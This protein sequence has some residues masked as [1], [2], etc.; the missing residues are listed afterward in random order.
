MIKQSMSFT[1]ELRQ[2][3]RELKYRMQELDAKTVN[4]KIDVPDVTA[5]IKEIYGLAEKLDKNWK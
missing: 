3:I 2:T 1:D 4:E 5:R